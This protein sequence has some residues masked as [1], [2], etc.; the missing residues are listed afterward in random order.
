M[1]I[2]NVH[3]WEQAV[4]GILNIMGWDLHWTGESNLSYDAKGKTPKG[5]DCVIEMKFRK[6]YYEY[7]MLEKS[8]YNAL[9]KLD[10]SIIKLY[11][12]NDPK[13]NFMFWLNN[14]KMPPPLAMYCPDTT[15][16]TKKRVLK[17]V[18]LLKEEDASIINLN[19]SR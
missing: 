6:K 11:F 2:K 17:P 4:V 13:G 18:Y 1:E 12:I 19:N 10:K 9:M 5:F 15:L 7:K 16:W 14:L 8:K 3:K